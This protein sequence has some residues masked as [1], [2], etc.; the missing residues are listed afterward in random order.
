MSTNK[1][2]N[3]LILHSDQHSARTLGC[4]GNSQVIT[5]NLDQ[6][7]QDGVVCDNAYCQSPICTPSRMSML[8]GQYVHNFGYYGL[9]GEK[10]ANLPNIF[11]YLKEYGY[12]TGAAGKTHTPAGWLTESCDCIGDG[13]GFEIPV[14]P[15]N[16]HL[17]EGCQGLIYNE[18]FQFLYEHGVADKREDKVLSELYEKRGHSQGQGVDTRP[19]D[20][21]VDLTIDAWSAEYANKFIEKS[22]KENKSFCFWLSLPHPHQVYTPAR[23]FWDM[24]EDIDIQLPENSEDD[25]SGRSIAAKRKQ[26]YFKENDEWILFEPKDW[27]SVRKRVLRGYYACVTQVD[28]AIGRVLRKLDELNIRENT[29]I[30]YLSDH[31]EFAGEHGMIEKAPGIGF[32]CV[33]RIPMIWSYKKKL[34]VNS[35]RDNIMEAIDV[36]PTMCQ[37]AGIPLPD[38]TDGCDIGPSLSNGEDVKHIAVT[39]HPVTKTIHTKKYKLTQYIPEYHGGEDFGEL[40]DIEN[41]P[42]ELNN[43]YFNP[44]YQNVV[45]DMRFKLYC[46]L[47]KSTRNVTVNPTVQNVSGHHDLFDGFSWDLAKI[48]GVSGKDGKV[49]FDFIQ[50]MID[51][52]YLNYI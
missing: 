6:L 11:S 22:V 38:W 1:Y 5:P 36:F 20:L 43:L 27:D 49:G 9:M 29:I 21:D 52:G 35:R 41:D 26:K 10:P 13:Y 28:E 48:R 17:E 2:P 47:V 3:I 14:T 45:N 24:Y 33:T 34:P 30:V 37:L 50:K 32:R 18:Y 25:L 4:Y 19:S 42:Y 40:F 12:A 39:E 51:N 31:G 15:W 7:A 23:K 16:E 8:S 46:W 44:K